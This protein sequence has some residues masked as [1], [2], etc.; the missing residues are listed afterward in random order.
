[1]SE[2]RHHI[3]PRRAPGWDDAEYDAYRDRDAERD[4][5]RQV[6][7]HRPDVGKLL[8]T[9]AE[10][11]A[12]DDPGDATSDVYTAGA[13]LYVAVTGQEPPL[14]PAR[15]RRPTELRPACTRA[16]ERIILRALQP[17]Q[18]DRYLTAA[19]MLEDFASDAGAFETPV[20]VVAPGSVADAEDNARWEKRLR[21]ALGDDYELLTLLGTGGF[22]RV[23]RVRDLQL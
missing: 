18:D 1:M 11:A 20:A 7:H 16:I 10:R 14:D 21:R 13:L 4:D 19:E 15:L 6:R 8:D 22:G 23:Y 12:K 5:N 2:A 9:A 17:A 3:L